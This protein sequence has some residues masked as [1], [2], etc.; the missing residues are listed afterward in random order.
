MIVHTLKARS[1]IDYAA[2]CGYFLARF[3]K[4]LPRHVD[5]KALILPLFDK[6]ALMEDADRPVTAHLAVEF[7]SG[8]KVF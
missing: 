2:C 7:S 3:R 1:C 8:G 4:P 6:I 5:G